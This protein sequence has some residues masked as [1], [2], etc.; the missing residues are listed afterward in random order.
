M[1][2]VRSDGDFLETLEHHLQLLCLC[3][4]PPLLELAG[5]LLLGAFA[6]DELFEVER[7]EK[8]HRSRDRRRRTPLKDLPSWLLRQRKRRECA[9]L[10]D[11]DHNTRGA[12]AAVDFVACFSMHA[13]RRLRVVRDFNVI[14][15]Q[16]QVC[17]VNS[18]EE[19]NI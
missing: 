17:M 8:I 14:K 4:V 3:I 13:D 7:D 11:D 10:R 18:V 12:A 16:Q 5:F 6:H 9:G 15:A 2:C 19:M 1:I